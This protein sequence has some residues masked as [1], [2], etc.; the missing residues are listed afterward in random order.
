MSPALTWV[1]ATALLTMLMWAPCILSLIGQ[2]G[3]VGAVSDAELATALGAPRARTP[4]FVAS[5][6]CMLVLALVL[7][8][9]A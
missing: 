7:L 1:G 5:W 4:V 9:C 8:G 6:V 3:L 2:T